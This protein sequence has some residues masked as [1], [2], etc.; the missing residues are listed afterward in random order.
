MTTRPDQADRGR[1]GR[2]HRAG[3]GLRRRGRPGAPGPDRRRRP[4]G[5]RV[6]ARGA[7]G[8][9]GRRAARST[10]RR[11]AGEPL[12][13]L[14]GVP[15][16]LKDV[17][18]TTDMP[19]TCGSRILEGWQPPYDATVTAAAARGRRGDPRQDQHGRVRDG[20]LHREL[21]L[22]A[23]PQPVGPEPDPRRLRRRL[24]APRSP[25]T[26]RRWRIG[27]D[28]G[29]S[30]RQPAAVCGIVGVKPTYG[31]SSRYG[32]GRLRRPRSTRRARCARTVLDAALLHEVIVR[33]RPVR[34][35]LDRRAGP[36]GRRRGPAG[37]RHRAAGRRGHASSAATAT[38]RACWPG[39]TRPSS[40]W[41]RSAPRSSRSPARTSP[42]RCRP[43]T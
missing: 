37:R 34:L 29:G 22:R 12:G 26:R 1:A 18:T 4:A 31:G 3:R 7:R 39:S 25:R 40:C 14:A 42:T 6:P 36:A 32:A 19:T 20:L 24:G 41:S 16:A 23:V 10:Q 30:I 27:T 28:T 15:L 9:A 38:S 17:F 2:G 13:P 5:A 33:A 35:D 21:R 11:G 43:T 8:R